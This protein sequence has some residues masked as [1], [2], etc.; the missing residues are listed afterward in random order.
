MDNNSELR[1]NTQ[2]DNSS[3]NCN[4]SSYFTQP[5]ISLFSPNNT[6]ND[7]EV[8]MRTRQSVLREID[9]EVEFV[10]NGDTKK[11]IINEDG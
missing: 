1:I 2:S 11:L 4:Y 3:N 6:K 7:Q 9:A 10:E 5:K 8:Q